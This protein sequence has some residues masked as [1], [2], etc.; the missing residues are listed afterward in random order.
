VAEVDLSSTVRRLL[1]DAWQLLVARLAE[2]C[3]ELR[4][5]A[6]LEVGSTGDRGRPEPEGA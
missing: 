6:E 3:R 1:G 5:D 2:V 4:G